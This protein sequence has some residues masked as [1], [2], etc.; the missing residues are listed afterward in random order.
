MLN[1]N[2]G[3]GKKFKRV[4]GNIK[5]TESEKFDF[6]CGIANGWGTET[7][8]RSCEFELKS[9]WKEEFEI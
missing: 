5:E 2:L 4:N 9:K 7:F 8:C 1:N 3:C 6:I